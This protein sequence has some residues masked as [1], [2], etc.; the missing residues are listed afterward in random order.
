VFSRHYLTL[1]KCGRK[2]ISAS[3]ENLLL[4]VFNTEPSFG[5]EA[6]FHQN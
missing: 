4:P 3:R 2:R 5:D 6:V 1:S